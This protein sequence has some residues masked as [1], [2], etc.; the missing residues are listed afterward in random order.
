MDE[1]TGK[2]IKRKKGERVPEMSIQETQQRLRRGR[3]M[4]MDLST[5]NPYLLPPGLQSSRESLHSLSRSLNTDDRYRPATIFQP[6]DPL[7]PSY[8]PSVRGDDSSSVTGG[9]S[10][11]G[12]PMNESRQNLLHS[13]NRNSRSMSRSMPPTT[14]NSV[15]SPVNSPLGTVSNAQPPVLQ[16]PL[17]AQHERTSPVDQDPSRA[18]YLGGNKPGASS[19][20]PP[21]ANQNGTAAATGPV[22]VFADP[23]EKTLPPL[24]D[25][26]PARIQSPPRNQSP[27]RGLPSNPRPNREIE[28]PSSPP[29]VSENPVPFPQIQTDDPVPDFDTN[30]QVES[31]QEMYPDHEPQFQQR[32]EQDLGYDINRLTIGVRPLP[33]DDPN[34]NPEQRANR[35]RSF[36]KEY[37]DDSSRV[38]RFQ[39]SDYH[40]E[41]NAEFSAY[42]TPIFDPDSGNFVTP[43][44]WAEPINRR[45]MTPPPRGP[46][47]FRAGP[48]GNI[49]SAGSDTLAGRGPRAYSSTSARFGQPGKPKKKAPPPQ[50]LATLPTPAML[51]DDTFIPTD[52]A[53]PQSYNERQAGARP[54]SP[55]GSFRP[56]SPL[57]PHKA[58][59]SSFDDLAIIPSP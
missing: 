48:R 59:V 19:Q 21:A 15:D 45:A 34:E 1:V 47:R 18:R 31:P 41:Y 43:T 22:N 53:P 49:P 39:P 5:S 9:S 25:E 55:L 12:F 36:Y 27:P 51:K 26:T 42:D 29:T 44:P 50:P 33:P 13:T 10:R 54:D 40:G 4:S 58:L 6:N 14:R 28:K 37:F 32:L 24:V 23:I 38:S 57:R 35:I 17:P 8:P 16:K 20:A 3:G 11:R 2:R 52:F 30:F 7:S 56:F 46:P